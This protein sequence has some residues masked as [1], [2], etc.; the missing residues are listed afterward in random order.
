MRNVFSGRL[1]RPPHPKDDRGQDPGCDGLDPKP[2]Q[3][4]PQVPPAQGN[5]IRPDLWRERKEV[6]SRFYQ[7]LFGHALNSSYPA[8]KAHMARSSECWWR[9]SVMVSP[10]LSVQ[11][12][13]SRSQRCGTA[14]E[15]LLRLTLDQDGKWEK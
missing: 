11:T 10:F 2:R 6:A 5:D 14:S 13:G 9:T 8:E 15:G 7:L 4:R 12:V 3:E 1:V